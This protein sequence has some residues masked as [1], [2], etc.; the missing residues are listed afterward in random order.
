MA[1]HLAWL[2]VL[3]H[4]AAVCNAT[5]VSFL[6]QVSECR[7]KRIDS[8][9]FNLWRLVRLNLSNNS[10]TSVPVEI[11][12]LTSLSELNLSHNNL[13]T[14]PAS[15]CLKESLQKSLSL[16]DLSHNQIKQLPLQI[17]ELTNLITLKVDNNVLTSLPPTIGRLFKLKFFS[18]SENKLTSLP[19]SF[20][21]LRLDSLDLFNCGD[22]NVP[23]GA[24]SVSGNSVPVPSLVEC[25]ARSIR[26]NR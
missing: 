3:F 1:G 17:C 23:T 18:A 25:C 20:M 12:K 24:V 5:V 9:I 14:F 2:A 4:F 15:V 19:A 6:L 10:L 21:R 11:A 22:E 8:R 7:M 26:K 16:L 13:E